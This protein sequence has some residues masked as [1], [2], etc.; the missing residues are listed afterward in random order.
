MSAKLI[1]HTPAPQWQ[2]IALANGESFEV[3]FDR[4]TYA[5]Q[6]RLHA[7][8]AASFRDDTGE[9]GEALAEHKLS[10]ITDW[11]GVVDEAGTPVPYRPDSLHAMCDVQPGLLFDLI[12]LAQS[13]FLRV[14]ETETKNSP[15]PS[16][17]SLTEPS[18]T[19][20]NAP[21]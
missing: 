5:Q 21:T 18:P 3:R 12:R 15:P 2:A 10:I 17:D 16:A 9:I 13:M 20:A 6:L 4:P 11:R 1:R 7:L 8:S 14:P 19:T